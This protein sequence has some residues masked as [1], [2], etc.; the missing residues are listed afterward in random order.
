MGSEA[1]HKARSLRGWK[2]TAPHAFS[3]TWRWLEPELPDADLTPF[4]LAA[5]LPDPMPLQEM[6]VDLLTAA[7]CNCIYSNLRDRRIVHPARAGMLCAM[8]PDRKRGPCKVRDGRT[9]LGKEGGGRPQVP[10]PARRARPALP[11]GESQPGSSSRE[12]LLP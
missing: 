12:S 3:D 10:P 6:S 5:S 9:K 7:T 8:T 4:C 2:Y 11:R 1:L